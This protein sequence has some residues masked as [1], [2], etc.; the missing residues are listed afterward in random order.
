MPLRI[1]MLIN[2]KFIQ[3]TWKDLTKN[4]YELVRR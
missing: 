4:K 3:K 1:W 2:D